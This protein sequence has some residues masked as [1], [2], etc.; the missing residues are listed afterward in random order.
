MKRLGLDVGTNSIGWC[1]IEDDAGLIDIGVRIFTDGRDP[2]SGASL[3]VDRRAARGAR[4]RRD[5]YLGRRS[6]FLNA[7][8]QHGLMPADADEAKLI[9]ERDPYELRVCALDR[10]LEP[11]EIGRA[12]FHLNQRRGFKSNRKAERRQKDSEGGKIASGAQALDRA[13]AESG[14]DT[15]GQFL[16]GRAEK[17][18][19]MHGESQDYDFYPQRRHVEYEFDRI[20]DTQAKHHPELLNET[21]RAHLHRILFFQRP[22]KEAEVGVCTFFPDE[23]RL[24]KAHPLFQERR[25]YEEVNHLQITTPGETARP[26]SREQRDALILELRGRRERSFE[27]LAKRLKLEPGQSFNKASETRT[28]LRGNEVHAAMSD[29]KRFGNA[30]AH[31]SSEHQWE[32]VERILE[33]EDPDALLAFLK[34]RGL[35]DEHAEAAA[36]APLPEGHG[37]LGETATRLILEELKKNVITY[38]QAVGRALSRSHSDERRGE[39]LERL[40]YYGELLSRDI[41]PGTQL[42]SDPPEKRWGKITN[43]TV[44]IGLRQLEKLINAVIA[45]HGRPDEIVVELA[46]DLKLNEKQKDEHKRRI[47]ETTA[48]AARRSEKLREMSVPDTG[49]NRMLLRLWEE[50]NPREVLDR[51]CPYCGGMIGAEMLF[52]GT[53]DIDHI[54]PYSRTLDDSPANK[55]VA[56]RGCNR[57]KGNK[58]PWEAWSLDPDRWETISQQAGRLHK[59]KQWRFGPDAME[60]FEKDDGFLARQLVD[61]QYLSRLARKYLSSLY[62]DRGEGSGHVYVIPGRMTAMLR[63]LWGLNSLLPDHNFVENEHSD[64]P[65]NR[66]DHR[67]HAIDAAVVAVTTRGLM[68]QISKAAGRAEEKDL[69]RL[70]ENLPQPWPGFREELG[71]KLTGVTVSHKPDHGRKGGPAP[72]RDVTAGRLHNDTAY[73]LTGETAVD[74]KTPI[75]VHRVPLMSL[76]PADLD[77][78]SRIPD[79]ALREALRAAVGSRTGKEF[80]HALARFAKQH[81]VFAGIRR[82]RVREALNVITINDRNGRPYKAYKGDANERFELWRLPDG[83]LK[84]RVVS[85]YQAHQNHLVQTRPHP[86]AKKL[87]QLRQNDIVAVERNGNARELL[88]VVGFNVSGR[89]TLSAANEG[90]NLRERDSASEEVDP[91]KYIYLSGNSILKAKAR[92]VRVDPLGRVFDPGPREP[93]V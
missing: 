92:Q 25:L 28:T 44:H 36:R 41:P 15:L 14:A 51:R 72:G 40:P 50:L 82:A 89:L 81:P 10:R 20:W 57:A 58:T 11:Y 2:K 66:L 90:G 42:P 59:S 12:L 85:M 78:P 55:V 91:F 30:W 88:R 54:L 48:A 60:R 17:R 43:P 84:T 4:R 62:A 68:Q 65:K 61:A 76:K 22:L 47:R 13:M 31:L 21:A 93:A 70:F 56:H 71:E 80:E 19:R 26:L 74:G 38:D 73:G 75:V 1:L 77:D 87:L 67:H 9:A 27:G 83:K 6:A 5:R 7:L 45:V 49:A 86:A 32:I 52:N 64:A 39:V 63:R 34:S 3:A 79:K 16:A 33:E 23:R 53:A 35:D 29:K 8:V 37:R 18:V 24:P 46:R 69:D